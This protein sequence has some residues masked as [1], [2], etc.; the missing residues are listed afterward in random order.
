[1]ILLALIS[2]N[3]PQPWPDLSN[4][5]V[6]LYYKSVPYSESIVTGN[7]SRASAVLGL[8]FNTCL[9]DIKMINSTN[10][11]DREDVVNSLLLQGH[12]T[13]IFG[14]YLFGRRSET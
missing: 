11:H 13:A 1:M 2:L 12:P 9:F 6:C 14:K 3:L 10:F 7:A 8:V 5:V 4:T